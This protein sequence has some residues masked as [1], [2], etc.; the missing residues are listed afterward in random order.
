MKKSIYIILL[1]TF[2]P[3]CY[4]LF[5]PF[6]RNGIHYREQFILCDTN[7]NSDNK[8]A[9]KILHRFI[10]KDEET[11]SDYDFN[12]T[13]YFKFDDGSIYDS[14]MT[15]VLDN[16][17]VIASKRDEKYFLTGFNSLFYQESY[18]SYK[19]PL[20]DTN[21]IS[22]YIDYFRDGFSDYWFMKYFDHENTDTLSG[23]YSNQGAWKLLGDSVIVQYFNGVDN[24]GPPF[25][26]M[27]FY[28]E[29]KRGKLIGN[30]VV[31]KE[32]YKYH[33]E[34]LTL[35]NEKYRVFDMHDSAN[36]HLPIEYV[37]DKTRRWYSN[38]YKK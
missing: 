3:S 6:P 16:G 4:L 1:V 18:M 9:N 31:L 33:E 20:E 30:T 25:I 12:K 24:S 28:L 22:T 10:D 32:Y 19:G 14:M 35:I 34:E 5:L 36:K 17:V 26:M 15:T 11:L 37:C 2:L 8:L 7:F 21:S 27:S 29:E 38:H 23:A 13:I